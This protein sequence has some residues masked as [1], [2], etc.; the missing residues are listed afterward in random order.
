M[1][2]RQTS[3]GLRVGRADELCVLVFLSSAGRTLCHGPSAQED[4]Q[5]MEKTG[6]FPQQ[7]DAGAELQNPL[8]SIFLTILS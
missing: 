2:S 4:R 3:T 8:F 5:L 1:G 7:I 6:N